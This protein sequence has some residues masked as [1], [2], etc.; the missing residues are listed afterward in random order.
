MRPISS[1]PTSFLQPATYDATPSQQPL[2]KDF[3]SACLPLLVCTQAME[4]DTAASPVPQSAAVADKRTA[5][6]SAGG[7]SSR[8]GQSS[9][10]AAG[11]SS[12]LGPREAHAAAQSPPLSSSNDA[13][14]SPSAVSSHALARPAHP[15]ASGDPPG[16]PVHA[17]PVQGAADGGK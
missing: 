12:P 16:Y 5:E 1:L 9:G 15:L 3:S 10:G 6:G 8:G 4:E 11:T 14:N 17:P 2:R 7:S 13:P